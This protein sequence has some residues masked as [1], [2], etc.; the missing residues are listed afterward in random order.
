MNWCDDCKVLIAELADHVKDRQT[1]REDFTATCRD[2]SIEYLSLS[3][4]A[5]L[6]ASTRVYRKITDSISVAVNETQGP[7]PLSSA[8]F[9]STTCCAIVSSSRAKCQNSTDWRTSRLPSL[10]HALPASLPSER[11]FMRKATDSKN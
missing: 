11:I 1:S 10:V 9:H 5:C 7:G 4:P 3:L 6:P 2:R 8:A